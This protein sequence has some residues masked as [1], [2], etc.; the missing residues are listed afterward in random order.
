MLRHLVEHQRAGRRHDALFVDLDAAQLGHV[1]AGGDDDGFRFQRLRL[2]IGARHLDL[3][4]RGD[5]AG[6]MK[7]V[8]LVFL[9]Q[10]IDALDVAVDALVLERHHGRKL[11]LGR[12]NADAH[13][14]KHATGLLEQLGGVQQRLRRDAADVQASAAEGRALLDHGGFQPK[15]RR[16]DGADIAAGAGADDDK[17]VSHDATPL[18]RHARPCTGHPRLS[19]FK[20]TRRGWPGQARP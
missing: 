17:V 6:A 13:F 9:E 7:S 3:A 4:G 15:L 19:L 12:R 16:A 2:A 14:A 5:A 11:E 8:D 20:E 1:G 18:L 10:K